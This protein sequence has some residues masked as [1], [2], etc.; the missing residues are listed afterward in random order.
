MATTAVDIVVK[1]N[2]TSKINK[3]AEALKGLDATS[4]KTAKN[5][6]KVAASAK[7]TGTAAKGAAGGVR[8]LGTAFKAALGPIGLALSA[9][10]GVTAAFKELEAADFAAAKVRTLGVDSDALRQNL[11]G[12]SSELEG[13]RSQVELLAASYDVASAGFND[14]NSAAQILASASKG[15]TGG[16][17]ELNTVANA[18]TSV[19]NAYGLSAQKAGSLVD[20][21][22]QTQNDGKIVVDEYARNIGKVAAAAAGLSVPI[23]EVNAAIAQS[24]AAGV[25]AE[26]AFTGLKGALARFASGEAQK[27]LEGTGIE[28]NAA[29]IEAE[30]LFG[31]LKKLEGLDTGQL[32]KA[33]GTEAGPA[34]LPIIQNLE[35]YEELIKNQGNSV[36]AAARAQTEAADTIAGAWKSVQTAFSDLF[37]DQSEFGELIK[38]VLQGAAITIKAF[39]ATLNIALKP[40]QILIST[41]I[42]LGKAIQAAFK[43]NETV[44]KFAA[45]FERLKALAVAVGT[46]FKTA[47]VDKLNAGIQE[48]QKRWAVFTDFVSKAWS[49][50]TDFLQ[51]AWEGAMKIINDAL[52]RFGTNLTEIINWIGTQWERLCNYMGKAWADW[53]RQAISNTV[54]LSGPIQ[55]IAKLLGFDLGEMVVSG[56]EAAAGAVASFGG[57]SAPT[58]SGGSRSSSTP[59]KTSATEGATPGGGST[60]G[61]GSAGPSAEDIASALRAAQDRLFA[62]EQQLAAQQEMTELEAIELE[63]KQAIAEIEREYGE[64]IAKALTGEE[65]AVLN[66]AKGL[67]IKNEELAAEKAIKDLR[68]GA[69]GGILEE[70]R[71]LQAKIEGKEEE[72]RIQ[73]KISDL[74]KAGGGTVSTAEASAAVQANEALKKQA[75]EADKLKS[76]YEG[77]AGSIAGELTSAFRSIIDGSKSAEQALSDAFKGIADAFLDMAMQMIQEWIKMQILGIVSSAFGGGAPI[78]GGGG[79]F[80]GGGGLN[81]GGSFADGGRPPVGKVSIVGEEGPEFF[82]P[83]APGTVLSNEQSRAAMN[84]YSP[85]NSIEELAFQGR[86]GGRGTDGISRNYSSSETT[87]KLETTV[88][89]GV[90]YATVDQVRAM[91]AQA[92]KAGA[93]QGEAA[94]LRA[95][96][97]NASTRKK[98][99]F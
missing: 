30:G 8:T 61:S 97:M 72:Y 86:Q 79:L 76:A 7:A 46:A 98:V 29:T 67:E 33:L 73:K 11:K 62:A 16:F 63:R 93:K 69:L 66:Q 43:E 60:G 25:Q 38:V 20:G 35:R 15:A 68:E 18:T 3:L 94:T 95:L 55:G 57:V 58:L 87:F 96:R 22:I 89:N 70:N 81:V 23:G 14:A 78:G 13:Q 59:P 44:Q 51:S 47:F 99:G 32:F 64:L 82:V 54:N 39:A 85:A 34:L 77:L 28:I 92:T 17:S 75:A 45:A 10:A 19:L 49:K 6:P 31:T 24:T 56:I 41:V 71:A 2:G 84:R 4:D 80:G 53:I 27:A 42:K 48:V 36:G 5:L 90:E 21:F 74:V 40:L 83:D 50:V 12:L 37:S 9:V 52:A 1:V 91:G 65:A 26:V 88:I